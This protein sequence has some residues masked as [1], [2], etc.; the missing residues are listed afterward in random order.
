LIAAVALIASA[1]NGHAAAPKVVDVA[2]QAAAA[3]APVRANAPV[4]TP[5]GSMQPAIFE[6][7]NTEV[8]CVKGE[9]VFE[10]PEKKARFRTPPRLSTW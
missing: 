1:A 4:T 7:V 5:A 8:L 6:V 9:F 10:S 3:C 2:K